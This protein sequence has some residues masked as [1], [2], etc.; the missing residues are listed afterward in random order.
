MSN[1]DVNTMD[2][3]QVLNAV[4]ARWAGIE[5]SRRAEA[6]NLR[7]LLVYIHGERTRCHP[8]DLSTAVDEARV[9]HWRCKHCGIDFA[10]DNAEQIS[11]TIGQMC[12]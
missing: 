5:L 8:T 4:S 7:R 9:A 10:N 2:P 1:S 12:V 6:A 3:V 11:K